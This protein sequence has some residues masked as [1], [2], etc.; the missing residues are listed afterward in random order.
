VRGKIPFFQCS[1]NFNYCRKVLSKKNILINI[2]TKKCSPKSV[3]C[4][5]FASV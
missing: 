4:W 5:E 1:Q 2:K 3:L